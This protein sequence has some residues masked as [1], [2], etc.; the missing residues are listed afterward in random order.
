M[1]LFTL[2]EMLDFN[3]APH[4]GKIFESNPLNLSDSSK[5][6]REIRIINYMTLTQI[7]PRGG[8]PPLD[9]SGRLTTLVSLRH[10]IW[11]SHSS[12][13]FGEAIRHKIYGI[14]GLFFR[15]L[16]FENA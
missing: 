13:S 4:G 16:G 6:A 10:V 14:Q 1:I 15:K 7:G 5:W 11:I 9:I 3:M 2:G 8:I 12:A